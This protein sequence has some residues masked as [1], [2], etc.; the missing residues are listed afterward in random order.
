MTSKKELQLAYRLAIILFLVGAISYAAIPAKSMD[1]PVRVMF[2]SAAGK[3]LFH[4]K[5]HFG[6][7]GFGVSCNDCHHHPGD[8]TGNRACGDCHGKAE[9]IEAVQQTCE[10]CHE[11]EDVDL[12]TVPG[13]ADAFHTQCIACHQEYEA[14]P[15]ECSQCHVM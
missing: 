2:T 3:V 1:Q 6:D 11:P 7:T 14:G 4:H 15:E 5:T 10:E 13:R 9:E 12:E 8:E